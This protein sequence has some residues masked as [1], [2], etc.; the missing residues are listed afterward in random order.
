MRSNHRFFDVDKDLGRTNFA[1]RFRNTS[2]Q[3]IKQSFD[4]F[5]L[6]LARTAVIEKRAWCLIGKLNR[7]LHDAR[8]SVGSEPWAVA[9]KL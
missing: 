2:A 8:Q 7:N 9:A 3:E 6:I 1:K 5:R 4:Q